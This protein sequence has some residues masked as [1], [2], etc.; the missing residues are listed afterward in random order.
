MTNI[1]C[2]VISLLMLAID[3]LVLLLTHSYAMAFLVG[4]I[5]PFSSTIIYLYY[6]KKY[7]SAFSVRIFIMRT[8]LPLSM[9]AL[10]TYYV[11]SYLSG[12]IRS[13]FFSLCVVI[14]TSTLL[15]SGSSLAFVVDS[16]TR[17]RLW[18][19]AKRKLGIGGVTYT[20]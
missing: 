8:Y 4:L 15:I 13:E 5:Q 18:H 7:M 20:N 16:Q 14:V 10:C 9:I 19:F 12:I 3:Y 1:L 17:M 2:G 11:C 6:C